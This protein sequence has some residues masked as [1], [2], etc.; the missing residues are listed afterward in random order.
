MNVNATDGASAGAVSPYI[1]TP[2]TVVIILGVAAIVLTLTA[3][4]LRLYRSE[5]GCCCRS[6]VVAQPTA[7]ARC[8]TLQ[9]WLIL[10]GE[11]MLTQVPRM[12][13]AA[14]RSLW[15][16]LVHVGSAH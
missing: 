3:I 4:G 15:L 5:H 9:Q 10:F 16:R 13:A 11:C 6:R 8:C 12:R 2:D 1:A 14:H 7:G